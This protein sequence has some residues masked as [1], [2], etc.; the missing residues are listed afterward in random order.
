MSPFQPGFTHPFWSS[1]DCSGVE[2]ESRADAD[3][4]CAATPVRIG[5]H[6]EFLFRTSKS[7]PNKVGPARANS[8]AGLLVL[9]GGRR[10]KRRRVSADHIHI[11][12]FTL[13]PLLKPFHGF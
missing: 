6:P 9:F 4:H 10:S 1:R 5:C 8:F 7:D 2:I 13:E 12:K 3:Q 11:G